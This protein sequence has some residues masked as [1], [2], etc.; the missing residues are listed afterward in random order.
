MLILT[1]G[2][3]RSVDEYRELLAGAAFDSAK[4]SPL[5]RNLQ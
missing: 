2:R 5:P 3:E 4:L 1:G